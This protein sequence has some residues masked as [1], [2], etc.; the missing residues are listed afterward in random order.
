MC[1][2]LLSLF[3]V[4]FDVCCCLCFVGVVGVCGLLLLLVV[5]CPLSSVCFMCCAGLVVCDVFLSVCVVV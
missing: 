1:C 3:V 4:L 5:S 2:V